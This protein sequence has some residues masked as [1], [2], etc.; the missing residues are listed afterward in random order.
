MLLNVCVTC[1]RVF[2]RRDSLARHISN[3]QQTPCREPVRYCTLCTKGFSSPRTVREHQRKCQYLPTEKLVLDDTPNSAAPLDEMNSLINA[4]RDVVTG[5]EV[6]PFML[7]LPD[8]MATP[9]NGVSMDIPTRPQKVTVRQSRVAPTLLTHSD[10]EDNVQEM[11]SRLEMLGKLAAAGFKE[12]WP[13]MK[14]TVEALKRLEGI[15]EEQYQVL[16]TA[17]H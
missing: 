8:V 17:I 7:P 6:I 4:P 9:T 11:F 3:H 12:I 14:E 1:K 10:D 15:T 2:S 16:I 13:A 5:M